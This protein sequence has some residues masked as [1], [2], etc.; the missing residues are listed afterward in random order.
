MA[1]RLESRGSLIGGDPGFNQYD[2]SYAAQGVDYQQGYAQQQSYAP[3]SFQQQAAYPQQ[4]YQTQQPVY[5]QQQAY[6]QPAHPVQSSFPEP[7]YVENPPITQDFNQGYAHREG[8]A[9]SGAA[10]SVHR[11]RF[12]FLKSRWPGAFMAITGVQAAICLAFEAY[13]FGRFQTSLHGDWVDNPQVQSQYKTI[14]TFLTLFIFGFI[15]ELVVVWDALR[16]RNT[17]QTIG[18]CIANL[19]LMTYTAL[20]VDQIKI[21][22]DILGVHGALKVDETAT[23]V[24]ADIR[25]YLVAIPAIIGLGSIGM[26]FVAWKLYQVF[27]WD[28]LKNIGADYR[29]KK[30][31]LHYQ[32]YI[33]LLKFDFFFFL[34]F[35]VQFVVI[36]TK[37][38]DPEF[39]LTIATIPVTIFILLAAAFFIKRENKPGM[40]CVIILYLGGLSYFVFKLVRI[41][42]PGHKEDYAAVRKSLTAFAVIT[43]LL[44][45][46]TIANAIICMTNFGK[47][48][49][50]HLMASKRVEEK[51]DLN[52]ISL[53]DVKP[54]QPSRMTIE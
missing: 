38:N 9:P 33:A 34:G 29:M 46:L 5:H 32:I 52:S 41:Y 12:S 3:Q 31:F 42:Q 37:T 21:A 39:A 43:I 44:I 8:L 20:Q 18:V 7:P 36:V 35:I 15:Y 50:T 48:L 23:G 30:R 53:S 49:K 17:I 28:I 2:Q 25:P 16:M 11:A 26:G 14:P 24:W 51:P 54:H 10:S 4:T 40:I 22:L 47:G 45:I 13:V 27:A 6:A 1:A 19:A